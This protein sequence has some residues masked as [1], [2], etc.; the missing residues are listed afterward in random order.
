MRK[1]AES[2]G[3][4]DLEKYNEHLRTSD[5]FSPVSTAAHLAHYRDIVGR[6]APEMLKLFH[7]RDLPR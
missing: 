7:V 6:I 1:V 4:D 2:A 3:F 5:E